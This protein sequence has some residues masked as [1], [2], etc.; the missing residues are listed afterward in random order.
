MPAWLSVAYGEPWEIKSPQ[1]AWSASS[2]KKG[3]VNG[4]I[5][6]EDALKTMGAAGSIAVI[7]R[8][9]DNNLV[10]AKSIYESNKRLAKVA[11]YAAAEIARLQ[12][13]NRETTEVFML[14]HR[15]RDDTERFLNALQQ[16]GYS[17]E[18]INKT[19]VIVDT[20]S[21]GQWS[22]YYGPDGIGLPLPIRT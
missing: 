11:D 22:L 10:D 18:V 13:K 12:Q 1:A 9:L 4:A 19:T 14:Y 3:G 2:S 6:P 20:P 16:R 7:R 21:G 17:I 5:P 15:Y 8:A